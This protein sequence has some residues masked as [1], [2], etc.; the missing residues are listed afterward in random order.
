MAKFT[1]LSAKLYVKTLDG[2]LLCLNVVNINDSTSLIVTKFRIIK[3]YHEGKTNH[4]GIDE[5][6]QR[7]KN[8]YYWPQLKDS[9]QSF[10]NECEICQQ[11][12]YE[13]HP[14]K[15][16]MNITPTPVRPFEIVHLDTFTLENH[17]FITLVDAFSKY[18]QAYAISS[19]N[20]TEVVDKLIQFFSHHDIPNCIVVDNGTE[21]KNSVIMELLNLH[22]I[23]LHFCSSN[24]SQ[25]N[26]IVERFHSTL[27][28]HVR[29]L[30][31]RGFLK[32]PISK[33][34]I[35]AIIAYNQS[36]HSATKCKPVD[37]IKG[38]ITNE[39]PF[40]INIDQTLL[41]DYIVNHKEKTKILYEKINQDLMQEKQNRTEKINKNRDP[42]D[43][44]Q[45]QQKV[46]VK[47]HIRQK[48]ANKFEKATT[49]K[50]T[51]NERKT[52]STE[53]RDKIHMDNLKRPLKK[54]YAFTK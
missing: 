24:H 3:S 52:A 46:Y 30:N 42:P 31:T 38:H 20:S 50:D 40:N 1:N 12:K 10:I 49:L 32:T 18:A 6:E 13:R 51:N 21:F 9:I 2:P 37:I 45:P 35:Y 47:K 19:L 26:G 22:K 28:E 39:N 54:P 17:K 44:F 48:T 53:S 23:K 5:T 43:I 16:Q 27:I 7:I 8:I 25:S 41:N 36:I 15:L 29:L 14:V 11:S 4:R 33:K 34:I